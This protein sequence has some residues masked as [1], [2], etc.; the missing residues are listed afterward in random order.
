[1]TMS[2]LLLVIAVK[3]D[4]ASEHM[5]VKRRISQHG[6]LEKMTRSTAISFTTRHPRVEVDIYK[7]F[8]NQMVQ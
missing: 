8:A 3:E 1:M 4:M 2:P 7:G 5:D 6:G